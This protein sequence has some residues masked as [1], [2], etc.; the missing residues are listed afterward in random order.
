MPLVLLTLLSLALA[1]CGAQ[2][3]GARIPTDSFDNNPSNIDG[4]EGEVQGMNLG[5]ESSSSSESDI[6]NKVSSSSS[7]SNLVN[8][9]SSNSSESSVS[10]EE[11]SSSS[12]SSVWSEV[13]SSS[14]ESSV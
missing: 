4:N 3:S 1:S 2:V 9:A 8:N 5:V 13:S 6:G 7:E 12:E 10:N 14:S 11:S